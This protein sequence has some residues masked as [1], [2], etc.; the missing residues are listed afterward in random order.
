VHAFNPG[1]LE[2]GVER[3]QSIMYHFFKKIFIYLL[4]VS[5]L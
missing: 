3:V 1:T 5:T 4:Y 2:S